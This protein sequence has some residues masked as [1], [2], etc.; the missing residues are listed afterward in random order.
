MEKMTRRVVNLTVVRSEVHHYAKAGLRRS[1]LHPPPQQPARIKHSPV[2]TQ[3]IGT[4]G[5]PDAAL[6]E[7]DSGSSGSVAPVRSHTQSHAASTVKTRVNLREFPAEVND[8][9]PIAVTD[10]GGIDARHGKGGS[11]QR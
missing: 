2:P 8:A 5:Q 10:V 4:T 3:H 1:R 6:A 11:V 9:A 7:A